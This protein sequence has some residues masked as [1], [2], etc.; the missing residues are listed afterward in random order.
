MLTLTDD[1]FPAYSP[2]YSPNA[3]EVP[4]VAQP[5]D[6]WGGL[7]GLYIHGFFSICGNVHR[8]LLRE[9]CENPQF[10]NQ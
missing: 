3:E 7:L 10:K 8:I 2:T 5:A 6:L 4:L 1:M 9:E